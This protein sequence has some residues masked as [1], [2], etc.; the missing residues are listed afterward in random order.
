MKVSLEKCRGIFQWPEDDRPREKLL[1]KGAQA[2]SSSELLAIILR[3]GTNG[4]SALDLGRMI[5]AKFKSFRNMADIDFSQLNE[6][7]GL[8]YAKI[9]Q[10]K[11]AIEIGRRLSEEKSI[12]LNRII[13]SSKD[14]S[15]FFMTRMRDLKKE[16][17]Q[18]MFLDS[19]NRVIKYLKMSEGT[20]NY[21]SPI[22]REIFQKALEFLAVSVVCVHN[23]PSGDPEPSIEDVDF[24]KKL[25]N[26]GNF[27]N[28]V[29]MD[30]I[31]IGDNCYYSFADNDRI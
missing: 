27:L 2:L 16:I 3:S 1:A 24:T 14:V 13:T 21:V 17:F 9:T 15:D 26:A 28:I 4:K 30:H 22:V 7:K 10:I 18:I 11:A 25:E 19:K 20:V 8:G 23:H 29:L 31:I 6:F 5:M 12:K